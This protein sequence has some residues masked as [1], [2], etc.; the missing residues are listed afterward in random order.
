MAQKILIVD[1][2]ESSRVIL[3]EMFK[4]EY[5]V[6][7]A[8]NGS[9][10]ITFAEEYGEQIKVI[11][12]DLIMDGMDGYEVMQIL[13]KKNLLDIIP[14]II[15]TAENTDMS[16]SRVLELGAY[17]VIAKPF[18]AD[19]V[20]HRVRNVISLNENKIRLEKL[21]ED[22]SRKLDAANKE[23]TDTLLFVIEQRNLENV[24]YASKIRRLTKILLEEV[25]AQDDENGIDKDD[26]DIIAY[27]ASLHDI[28]K[29]I[30]PDAILNKPGK[31]TDEEYEMMKSHSVEGSR[32]IE[33]LASIY[34]KKYLDYAYEICRYHHERSDGTGYPDGLLEEEIPICAQVVGITDAYEALTAKK[35]YK[36]AYSHE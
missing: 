34:R 3:K 23:V 32:M 2:A 31:L 7:E 19:V 29:M 28:G 33:R 22:L 35:S 21:T 18:Y 6:L 36:P 4:N 16:E 9:D 20:K 27:A 1:D 11:L 17:D 13:A 10:A 8:S 25:V 14:V 5:S 15:I 26:I 24:D 30:I 12:L